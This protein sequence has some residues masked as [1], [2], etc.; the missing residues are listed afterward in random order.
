MLCR[1]HE[2]IIFVCPEH[3]CAEKRIDLSIDSMK[4]LLDV[5]HRIHDHCAELFHVLDLSKLQPAFFRLIVAFSTSFS[6][7]G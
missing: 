5:T 6:L 3:V 7:L 1:T 4:I 2:K